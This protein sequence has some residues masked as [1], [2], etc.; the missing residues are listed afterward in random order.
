MRAEASAFPPGAA[1]CILHDYVCG[2]CHPQVVETGRFQAG[3]SSLPRRLEW[4]LDSASGE[5]WAV[6][7]R[8]QFSAS[9][10]TMSC[11]PYNDF[12]TIRDQTTCQ[13]SFVST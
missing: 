11:S 12:L 5:P 7:I 1:V 9:L 6:I 2:L 8:K 4:L 3:S 10:S 13:V